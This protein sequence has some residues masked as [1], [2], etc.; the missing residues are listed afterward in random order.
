MARTIAVTPAQL[1]AAAGNI[2]GLAKDYY[3][4]YT[5]LYRENDAMASTWAGKDNVDYINQIAGFQE[6]FQ[7]MKTLMD[8]YADFLRKSARAYRETQETIAGQAR[9]L[10][11]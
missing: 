9:K 8:N 10:A 11:N 6:D 7:K 4:A 2:E 3:T 1:E 5:S